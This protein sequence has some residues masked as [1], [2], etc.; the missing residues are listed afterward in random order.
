VWQDLRAELH[1]HGLEV[2]TVGM[3]TAGPE[4]C[5]PFIE[6]ARPEHPSLVDVG[7]LVSE[8]FGVVNI[9]NAVWIDED[10]TITR[11][12]EPAS[13]PRPAGAGGGGVDPAA[14]PEHMREIFS[15]AAR[16]RTDPEA[17][18]AALRDWVRHGRASRFALG[19]DEVVARSG[20]RDQP[21]AEAAA[22]FALA[23]HLWRSG[24][25][26]SAVEHFRQA[27][28]LQPENFSYK[29]QAWSLAAP[30]TGPFERFWQGPVEG[31]EDEWPYD[32][33]WLSEVRA[34]GAEN[35][36]PPLEL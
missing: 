36:Y 6:A 17:Y 18:V 4:A 24:R 10:G 28:R 12:A 34:M 23:Q 32:S 13:V 1:P 33:D 19:P 5:R 3:D 22:H 16:I 2:V 20:R 26:G 11:P 29:R 15:E 35:Y 9:P 31:R 21:A 8:R 25:T 27:H 7:H 30:G 14:M